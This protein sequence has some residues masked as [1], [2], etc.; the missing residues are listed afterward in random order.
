MDEKIDEI[1]IEPPGS[2]DVVENRES[3]W[4]PKTTK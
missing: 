2:P 4:V 1:D 3:K